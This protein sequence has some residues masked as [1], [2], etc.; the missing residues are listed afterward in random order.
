MSAADAKVAFLRHPPRP[1]QG[2]AN[3]VLRP[4]AENLNRQCP[5]IPLRERAK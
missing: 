1:F 5:E 3:G 4:I 2:A